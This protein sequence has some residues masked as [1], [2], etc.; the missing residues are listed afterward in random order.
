MET[1]QK[2]SE[3]EHPLLRPG[4]YIGSVEPEELETYVVNDEGGVILRKIVVSPGLLKVF[5]ELLVNAADHRVRTASDETRRCTTIKVDL[6]SEP[7]CI[8]V[9]NDGAGIDVR[10]HSEL[11]IWIPQMIFG[12]LRT[13]NN[14]SDSEKRVTGGLNGLGAKLANIFAKRFRLTTV[15]STRGLIY[16]QEWTNNMSCV[17]PPT[18]KKKSGKSFTHIEFWPDLSRFGY[19]DTFNE[20][21]LSIFRRRVYDISVTGGSGTKTYLD[22][23]LIKVN[24]L[25]KYMKLI[26]G[27]GGKSVYSENTP[28][29]KVGFTFNPNGG[30]RTLSFV[31]SIATY[32][33]GTHVDHVLNPIIRAI[34]DD[35][36]TKL[37]KQYRPTPSQIREHIFLCVDALIE[38]P[39]FD[40]QQKEELKTKAKDFGSVCKL[41]KDTIEKILKTGIVRH[42]CDILTGK[43]KAELLKD[44]DGKK[45]SRVSGIPKLVDAEWA[46]T[47][48]SMSCILILTEGDSAKTTAIAAIS[49]LSNAD[50]KRFGVFP[51]RGKLMNICE[52]AL[53]KID[54]NQEIAYIKK[55]LGLQQGKTY[56][57]LSDLRYGKVLFMTDQDEDGSHIKGLLMNLF[58]S[59]WP[60]LL[61]K[62]FITSLSTPIIRVFNKRGGGCVKEFYTQYEY[63]DWVKNEDSSRYRVK[64]YKGL[65]T[66]TRQEAKEYLMEWDKKIIT[67]HDE[68]GRTDTAIK[69]AFDPKKADE[70]KEWLRSYD[71]TA[72]LSYFIK[73]VPT[74]DFVDLELKH[75]SM[76]SLKRAIPDLIDGMTPSRRKVLYTALKRGIWNQNSEVRVSQLAGAVSEM[77][78]Y[79][80]GEASLQ[81]TII[82]LAQDYCGSNNI[83]LLVPSGAFGSRL[84]GGQ[85]SA[86]PRYIMT[87][88]SEIVKYIFVPSDEGILKHVTDDGTIVEPER[89]LPIIPMILVN[90]QEGIGT[91]WSTYVPPHNPFDIVDN[92]KSRLLGS[93]SSFSPM[94]PWVKGFKGIIELVT[95]QE[96]GR[97]SCL[98]RGVW[99]RPTPTTLHITELPAGTWTSTWKMKIVDP[100]IENKI[101]D[102][103][104]ENVSDLYVDITLH[105]KTAIT[106]DSWIKS[107][108]LEKELKL[109]TSISLANM[110]LFP[111]E[112]NH[113]KRY[114]DTTEIMEEFFQYRL[115]KYSDRRDHLLEVLKYERDLLEHKVRFINDILEENIPIYKRTK[116]EVIA[117]VEEREYRKFGKT[118]NDPTPSYNYIESMNLFEVTVDKRQELHMSYIK[119]KEEVE[120]LERTTTQELWLNDLDRL[121]VFLRKTYT[122]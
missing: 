46:G 103:I 55:I 22:G 85:D 114:A 41:D 18:I 107:G 69:L 7:G 56:N 58:Y 42:V 118:Y 87:F 102:K 120:Q 34:Q 11:D 109:I 63:D 21:M 68:D 26:V 8:K 119:K 54:A 122:T 15:D 99:K 33:A 98:I 79:H 16:T 49:N 108:N 45:T 17:N 25:D 28:R 30:Y 48:K 14:F 57:D 70:R 91:G 72:I 65:G 47:S 84:M 110:H 53:S 6:L 67:Y 93:T 4:M 106:L 32:K 37:K 92:L 113:V 75:F 39:S 97:R 83:N 96:S 31:N 51:L 20:D 12:D 116:Q 3:I 74:A 1:Y 9:W 117:D 61:H 59:F 90:S 50:K 24:T 44:S 73:R 77:T 38:N 66:S 13:G 121:D 64:F 62:D 81:Q 94:T 86:S 115:K 19:E 100:L 88:L 5:D 76:S 10:K 23:K 89:Y 82:R 40:S 2:I 105:F 36:E 95:S 35:V 80:H 78:C 111:P 60:S 71:P 104:T 29:W 27:S 112:A 101:V 43:A 52:T